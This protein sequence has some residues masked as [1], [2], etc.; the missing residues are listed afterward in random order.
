MGYVYL[1]CSVPGRIVIHSLFSEPIDLYLARVETWSVLRV[2]R[3]TANNAGCA[4]GATF[5]VRSV[6][7]YITEITL[8]LFIIVPLASQ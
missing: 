2:Q 5:L 1:N 3:C 4:S 6:S 8:T 7:T